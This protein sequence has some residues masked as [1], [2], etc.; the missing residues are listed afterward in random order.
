MRPRLI[1][2]T[3]LLAAL[4]LGLPITAQ[5][6][7]PTYACHVKT[8]YPHNPDTFTQ[9]LF[10]LDGI[11]YES[12]GGFGESFLAQVDLPTGR[13]LRK[14]LLESQYFAEGITPLDDKLYLLTW[15]S[16]TGFTHSLKTLE[17]LSEF[18]YHQHGDSSEGWGLAYI[19]PHFI[20]TSGQST[21]HIHSRDDFA[22][23]RTVPVHDAGKPV[24]LLN[25]LEYVGGMLLANVWKK[26]RIAVIN[27]QSGEV[28][29]W[30]DLTPLRK[31][32]DKASGV[33][34]GIAYDR[35]SERLYVTGKNWDK[36]FEIS[37]DEMIWEQPVEAE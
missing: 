37:I 1:L 6:G 13:H 28:R 27:P 30:I 11:L 22:L 2:H 33:S 35:D 3:L 26:D 32:L 14:L 36:L 17:R 34:N 31:R 16:G 21:L 25:E 18:S 12:S 10:F 4:I 9:G 15:L 19:N 23:L 5:A 29:A 20:R 8:E 24:R 7:A